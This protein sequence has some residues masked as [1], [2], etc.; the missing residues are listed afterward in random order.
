MAERSLYEVLGVSSAATGEQIRAAYRRLLRTVHPD[1]GGNAAL[2]SFVQDAYETLGDPAKRAA[3]DAVR[4]GPRAAT[5]DPEPAP[6]PERPTP[7]RPPSPAR[8]TK[9]AHKVKSASW[10]AAGAVG[11][12]AATAIAVA[13]SSSGGSNGKVRATAQSLDTPVPSPSPVPSS[14]AAPP[15]LVSIAAP[16]ARPTPTPTPDRTSDSVYA[17]LARIQAGNGCEDALSVLPL[18]LNK[19][20]NEVALQGAASEADKAKFSDAAWVPLSVATHQAL[21][22]LLAAQGGAKSAADALLSDMSKINEICTAA[23]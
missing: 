13:A 1:V 19:T 16:V 6:E 22:D 12:V 20:T 11:L 5:P 14:L 10:V 4:R 3:Y 2:F 7:P 18:D 17:D 21:G 15:S 8:P 9:K 23:H